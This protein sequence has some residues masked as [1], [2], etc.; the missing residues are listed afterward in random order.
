MSF[1]ESH[2]S[3]L[4]FGYTRELSDTDVINS[5]EGLCTLYEN[6]LF[7]ARPF[8]NTWQSEEIKRINEKEKIRVKAS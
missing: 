5:Y 4:E 2:D 8:N 7:Y 3:Y 6:T 1:I